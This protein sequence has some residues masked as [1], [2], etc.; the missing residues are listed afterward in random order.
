[1]IKIWWIKCTNKLKIGRKGSVVVGR[2]VT[3]PPPPQADETGRYFKTFMGPRNRFQ[4]MNSASLCSLAGRYDNPNPTRSLSP[5]GRLKIPAWRWVRLV[6]VYPFLGEGESPVVASFVLSW[7]NF[8]SHLLHLVVLLFIT[9]NAHE[10]LKTFTIKYITSRSGSRCH[11]KKVLI[12]FLLSFRS[13]Y[14]PD[15]SLAFLP[16][17]F[18][19]SLV[20]KRLPPMKYVSKL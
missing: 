10:T 8:L 5:I 19:L 20:N 15:S 11:H 17:P 14:L 4:G 7:I 18:L 2:L 1:M 3:A 9:K 12:L 6:D 16:R 13:K